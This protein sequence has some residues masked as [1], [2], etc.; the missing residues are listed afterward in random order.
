LSGHTFFFYGSLMDRDMLEAVLGRTTRHL[1]FTPGW[2]PGYVAQ[3]ARG[4]TFPT[5]IEHRTGRVDGTVTQGLTQDDVD[6][7]VYFE[8]TD[9]YA[10]LVVD[11]AT[12][13]TD[14]AAQ[15]FMATTALPSTGE[16]WS[17]DRWR[18]H[19]KPLLL[20]VTRKMMREHYGI[21]P[22]T[23]VD[24]VWHRIKAEVEAE[25]DARARRK[26]KRSLRTPAPKQVAPRR[27]APAASPTRRPRES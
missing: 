7:I 5:L 12:A 4:Y 21:T 20:A 8:D 13:K 1:T 19:D 25:I 23:Q 10:P 6:R 2:L 3:T 24:A 17:F 14:V 9:E 26:P 22:A 27:A 18:K 11:I 15:I 16:A